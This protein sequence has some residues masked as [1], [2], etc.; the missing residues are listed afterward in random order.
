MIMSRAAAEHN[1]RE[2]EAF[3][4]GL[5]T[6]LNQTGVPYLIG[7]T[8]AVNEYIGLGRPTKDLDIFCRPGDFPRILSA[9]GQNYQVEIEDER[10]IAKIVR[11]DY[12]CDV[13]FGSANMVAPVTDEWFVQEQWASIYGVR[14]RLLPPTELIW[15]KV[16]IMDRYKFDGND[17]VHVLLRKHDAIDWRR[18]LAYMDQHWEVLLLHL[19]RYRYIY[20]TERELVPS[21]V[22]D[23]LLK[24][25]QLQSQMPAART[26]VCRG[27]IFSRED[28]VI[29]IT[30]W[31]YAD[32]VGEAGEMLIRVQQNGLGQG[33]PC[34]D[35]AAASRAG[36]APALR[37]R[38]NA[39]K[40]RGGG[41]HI[42]QGGTQ[43][44]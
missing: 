37:G 18:L 35:P 7:G 29:D 14:V 21:W 15:S 32:L 20:P 19:L 17:V 40:K 23:E 34:G 3:Y 16:F 36:E 2:A 42:G 26:R 30:E 12:F 28:F 5:L 13:V 39:G 33:A 4:T 25:L 22:M 8:C 41:K 11:G 24:R 38:S 27:R 44:G 6:I 1:G 10:W 9:C 43:E 31:G